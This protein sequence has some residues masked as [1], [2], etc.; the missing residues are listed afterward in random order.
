MRMDPIRDSCATGIAQ[1]IR[2]GSISFYLTMQCAFAF[3]QSFLNELGVLSL[4]PLRSNSA[5]VLARSIYTT[6]MDKIAIIGKSQMKINSGFQPDQSDSVLDFPAQRGLLQYLDYVK[7]LFPI[8]SCDIR[9]KR[10]EIDTKIAC[11][12]PSRVIG[13]CS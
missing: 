5:Y 2:R 4:I 7:F 10:N 8:I 9:V 1:R 3:V 13:D 11:H 6:V 12:V